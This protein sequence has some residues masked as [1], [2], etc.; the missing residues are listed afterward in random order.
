MYHDLKEVYRW[1]NRKKDVA[2]FVAKRLLRTLHK[3]D[4]IWVIVDR[5]TKSVHFL[6]VKS[7]DTAEQY[8]QLYV[9]EIVS[10]HASIQMVPF[11]ALHG[12]RCRSLIRWF[13]TCIEENWKFQ[14]DDWVFLKVSSMKGVMRFGKKG[15]LIPR[16]VG[17]YRITQRIGQVAYRLELPPEM[18]LVHPVFHVSMLKKM[19]GDPSTTVPIETIEVN[20]ELSYEEILVAILD[21]QVHKLRNKEVA[22]VKVPWQ[23]Q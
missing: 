17:L 6:L 23:S 3:F 18:S 13:E 1:D 11:E 9:K 21:R 15:K 7:T 19:V 8:A 4:S 14:V 12:R 10:F 5:H 16:Y 2:D 22:S 20:K